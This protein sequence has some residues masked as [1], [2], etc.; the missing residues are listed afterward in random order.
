MEVEVKLEQFQGPFS[1]LYHLIEKNKIDLADIP[2]A[3]ITDQYLA[4]VQEAQSRNLDGMSEFLVM[5]ATLLE[6]KSRLLL[7]KRAKEADETEEE[8][9]REALVRKLLEYK[10][11]QQA[12]QALRHREAEA[13][14]VCFKDEDPALLQIRQQE[15]RGMEQWLSGV[16]LED[17]YHAFEEVC[18]RQERKRDHRRSTFH[19]I[20]RDTFTVEEK[21]DYLR[22]LLTLSKQMTFGEIFSHH[23]TKEEVVITFLALLELM[24]TKEA[25]VGQT[26]P[27][28]EIVIRKGGGTNEAK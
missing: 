22:D 9:P 27:F 2:I 20:Q 24:K 28:G 13:A 4:V 11:F 12:A 23:A 19:R 8:D 18:A 5:A 25:R 16:T 15:D 7:P 10:K 3:Q 21:M 17:L 6:M 1:L 26:S 14:L